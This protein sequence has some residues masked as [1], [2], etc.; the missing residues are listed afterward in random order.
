MTNPGI[1][2]QRTADKKAL[3]MENK[4]LD[5]AYYALH[6]FLMQSKKTQKYGETIPL[7]ESSTN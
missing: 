6:I 7:N 5:P 1:I 4:N 3:H 2:F